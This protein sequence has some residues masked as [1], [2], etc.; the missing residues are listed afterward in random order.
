ME[1]IARR[2][3]ILDSL[4]TFERNTQAR[5]KVVQTMDD[6]YAQ[7]YNLITSPVAKKAFNLKEEDAKTREM[8]GRNSF[9][10]AS[11]H[12]S[13]AATFVGKSRST[14]ARFAV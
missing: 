9:G 10:Q 3:S 6:F 14:R 7:A 8:Y 2:K 4:D 11:S 1:R 12:R 13:A 5:Q